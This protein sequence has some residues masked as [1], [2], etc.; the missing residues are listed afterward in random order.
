MVTF[1]GYR[2]YDDEEKH[3]EDAFKEQLKQEMHAMIDE[4]FDKD[5]FWIRVESDPTGKDA[6]RSQNSIGWKI[7]I[8]QQ[9]END[10]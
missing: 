7:T 2:L 9:G 4:Q 3:L 10:K 6:L 8:H 1:G 5:D